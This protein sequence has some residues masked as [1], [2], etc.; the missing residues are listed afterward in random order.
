M[1]SNKKSCFALPGEVVVVNA[2]E[3]RHITVFTSAESLVDFFASLDP[4]TQHMN[5]EVFMRFI[6]NQLAVRKLGPVPWHSA[7]AFVEHFSR[8]GVFEKATLN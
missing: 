1:K 4:D 3:V 2:G 8:H 7:H 6:S 5:T